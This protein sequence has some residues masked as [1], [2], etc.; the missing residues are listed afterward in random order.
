MDSFS[1]GA[2]STGFVGVGLVGGFVGVGLAAV[3]FVG[4]SFLSG[5]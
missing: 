5:L 3:G 4:V 1:M 2:G